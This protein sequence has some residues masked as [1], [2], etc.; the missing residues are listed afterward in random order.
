MPRST[1]PNADKPARKPRA[2]RRAWEQA[3]QEQTR[4]ALVDAATTVF[5]RD[6]FAP[7]TIVAITEEAGVSNGTFYNYFRTKEEILRAVIERIHASFYAGTP[8]A[9][10]APPLDRP[11]RRR[12]HSYD[13]LRD[14]VERSTRRFLTN[15]REH[16]SFFILLDEVPRVDPEL[17]EVRKALRRHVVDNTARFIETLQR[18]GLVDR[19]LDA[20][21]AASALNAMVDRFAYLWFVVGEPF[22]EETSVRT[23]TTFWL[24]ALEITPGRAT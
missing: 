20:F 24:N 19:S 12:K 5:V 22:D 15:Y 14:R 13:E 7:T 1:T 17:T 23:L 4:A 2:G 18:E 3:R 6:G 21:H 11:R 9:L 8:S 10:D 16:A